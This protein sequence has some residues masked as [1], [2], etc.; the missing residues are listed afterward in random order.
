MLE[1]LLGWLYGWIHCL[2]D[3]S[4]WRSFILSSLSSFKYFILLWRNDFAL[5]LSNLWFNL[6][7][8]FDNFFFFLRWLLRVHLAIFHRIH[9]F[10]YLFAFIFHHFLKLLDL[11]LKIIPLGFKGKYLL[12][13]ESIPRHDLIIQPSSLFLRVVENHIFCQLLPWDFHCTV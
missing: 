1:T 3:E 7:F 5:I 9:S 12:M 4:R 6:F 11:F 8:N 13:V 2:F 10:F